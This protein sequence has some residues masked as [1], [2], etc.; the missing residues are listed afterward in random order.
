[1]HI[2]GIVHRDIKPANLLWSEDHITVKISD[3]GVSIYEF[4]INRRKDETLTSEIEFVEL[5]E[6]GFLNRTAGTP[7]FLAPEVCPPVK[8]VP[9]VQSSKFA[10]D[11]WA[12]GVTYY[13]LLFGHPPWEAE[14]VWSLLKRI[15][16][17]DF[18]IPE[19]MGSDFLETGG[20]NPSE[21]FEDGRGVLTI[22]N[23]LL[24]KDPDKRLTLTGLKVN[25]LLSK[26]VG[27]SDA[28]LSKF[29]T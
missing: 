11:T 12:L 13:C 4:P 16:S 23:G 21:A 22:L 7:S 3:F 27:L 26:I 19:T 2:Q 25:F 8:N 10:L 1:V 14:D 15:A 18:E 5:M 28:S 17:D 29:H 24:T 20:R 9:T 6:D